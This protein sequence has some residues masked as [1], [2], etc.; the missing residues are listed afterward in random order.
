MDFKLRPPS[1]PL[2][3][4]D[5]Y[6]S[7][8]SPYACLTDGPTLHWTGK[9]NNILGS[10]FV[11]GVEYGF[12]GKG[13]K[14]VLKQTKLNITAFT[15]ELVFENENIILNVKFCSP[16]V[17][18]DLRLMSEPISYMECNFISKDSQKHSVELKLIATEELCLNS[19]GEGEAVYE[20][21]AIDG[22]T[23]SRLG[24]KEQNILARCGDDIRIDWGY[25][26]LAS[27]SPNANICEGCFEE[28]CAT[29]LIVPL[30]K[31]KNE[32]VVFA[33]DDIKSLIYFGNP[34][35]AY[36]KKYGLSIEE[37]IANA[38][39]KYPETLLKC[40]LF[41]S[42]LSS[43]ATKCGNEKYS[44]ILMLSM[45]QVMSAHKLALDENGELVYISKECF[46]N[47]CAATVDVTY[48]SAPL[49]IL[50]NSRLLKAMLRPI[51]RYAI[52]EKWTFDF[53][54]HD[55]GTYPFCNGQTYFNNDIEHQ[56]PV[57]ECGNMLILVAALV[58]NE[59]HYNFLSKNK[60]LLKKWADYLCKY[61]LDPANQKCTDDFSGHLAHNCNL[62]VKAI[63][64]VNGYSI[65]AKY[66][67]DEEGCEH[68]SNIAQIM[69]NEWKKNASTD[70]YW[71][72]HT[73]DSDEGYSLKY[74]LIWDKLWNS[75]LFGEEVYSSEVKKY[76]EE[77]NSYGVPLDQRAA[78]TKSDWMIWAACLADNKEDFC[79]LADTVWSAYNDM[80][81]R[82]PMTDWYDS[83][84]AEQSTWPMPDNTRMGFQHRSV[85]GGLFMK[86]LIENR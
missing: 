68:Y 33:Y 1:V 35:E 61:G 9:E 62:S 55:I 72:K 45:R 78:Y 57:E 4:V 37:V 32:L 65:I 71:Y 24:N 41:S 8:W 28:M 79:R 81:S 82:V 13:H 75:N 50:F 34:I 47:G 67:G 29:E 74:N 12:L 25:F 31:E 11:D 5:P 27:N 16:L 84:T 46:S 22:I 80:S 43:L 63:M 85:Q 21:I 42:R 73:F 83:I 52:S 44:E 60:N 26:Y 77:L 14:N 76:K 64:G 58:N 54:P 59:R 6:F 40:Y 18:D 30:E 2:I 56:M 17:P 19:R 53:A 3:N 36:W 86:L 70:N 10:V 69:A 23:C 51:F 20:K 48:P 7:V 39:E 15:T 49:F 66:L 38:F